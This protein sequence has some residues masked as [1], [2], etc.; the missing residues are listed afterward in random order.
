MQHLLTEDEYISLKNE[1][2]RARESVADDLQK[3]CTLA[4]DH[5]PMAKAYGWKEGDP[6]TVWGCMYTTNNY[7]DMC[8][9]RE[10]CPSKD[11]HFSK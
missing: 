6:L 3:L 9:V 10:M 11:K 1:G 8:P 2:K 7:C 4:A 5:A